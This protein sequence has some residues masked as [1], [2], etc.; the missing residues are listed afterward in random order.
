MAA[1]K[2][3]RRTTS[4]DRATFVCEGSVAEPHEPLW[5]T[6]AQALRGCPRGCMC[7]MTHK[8]HGVGQ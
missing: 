4:V 5:F 7:E 8:D 2:K 3:K 1:S 6:P